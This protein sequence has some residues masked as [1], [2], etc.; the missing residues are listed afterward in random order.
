MRFRSISYTEPA[1]FQFTL[2]QNHLKSGLHTPKWVYGRRHDFI[3]SCFFII[4]EATS[5][6]PD[7]ILKMCLHWEKN[8]KVRKL[9]GNRSYRLNDIKMTRGRYTAK[10]YIACIF[11]KLNKIKRLCDLGVWSGAFSLI[12][13]VYG[14]Y[15][16]Q[17]LQG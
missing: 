15:D 3:N 11:F 17:S 9:N 1:Y 14:V 10:I 5:A 16:L 6:V 7:V 8:K 13:L 2:V 4:C 12:H